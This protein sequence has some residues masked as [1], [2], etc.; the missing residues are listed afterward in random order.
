MRI[1]FDFNSQFKFKDKFKLEFVVAISQQGHLEPL[2]L[3]RVQQM[4]ERA[5]ES[6]YFEWKMMKSNLLSQ[7]KL[8]LF[9]VLQVQF[10]IGS[11]LSVIW[12][13]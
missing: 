1:E 12:K 8:Q 13:I 5:K 9:D 2:C 11:I 3:E 4:E 6:R 7:S 10:F